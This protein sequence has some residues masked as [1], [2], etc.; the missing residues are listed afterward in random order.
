MKT[1]LSVLIILLAYGIVGSDDYAEAK[2]QE[3]FYAR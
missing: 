3:A 1:I 2:A